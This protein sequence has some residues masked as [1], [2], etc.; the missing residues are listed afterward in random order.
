MPVSLIRQRMEA[1]SSARLQQLEEDLVERIGN[2]MG[3]SPLQPRDLSQSQELPSQKDRKPSASFLHHS[4]PGSRT[5]DDGMEDDD[6]DS[7]DFLSFSSIEHESKSQTRPNHPQEQSVF[8]SSR[9]EPSDPQDARW[10]KVSRSPIPTGSSTSS[11]NGG[12]NLSS[13]SSSL[14][15]ESS[16]SDFNHLSHPSAPNDSVSADRHPFGSSSS[17]CEPSQHP[18]SWS[19]VSPPKGEH[20]PFSAPA[21]AAAVSDARRSPMRTFG[22]NRSHSSQAFGMSLQH[23]PHQ[24]S[25]LELPSANAVDQPPSFTAEDFK[26]RR[27]LPQERDMIQNVFSLLG[28]TVTRVE[29][30]GEYLQLRE[31]VMNAHLQSGPRSPRDEDYSRSHRHVLSILDDM[32][33]K[34]YHEIE[35]RRRSQPR[36]PQQQQM[37][38]QVSLHPG[39]GLHPQHSQQQGVSGRQETEGS[40]VMMMEVDEEP[41]Q[42]QRSRNAP[43]RSPNN[44]KSPSSD[45]ENSKMVSS[46]QV[47]SVRSR[48]TLFLVI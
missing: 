31:R 2:M 20:D 17:S 47:Q 27:L 33:A 25:Q 3:I 30:Q 24:H 41:R 11:S 16:P 19:A 26:R 42:F 40:D 5:R 9:L 23:Q 4:F 10:S 38:G 29:I 7:S 43:Q 44:E 14:S 21:A 39:S 35:K 22:S 28:G 6:D 15:L 45:D 13:L 46:S 32:A 8:S 1:H 12:R 36:Q 18:S 34:V 37:E 48:P